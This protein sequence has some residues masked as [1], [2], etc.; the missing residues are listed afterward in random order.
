MK[1]VKTSSKSR[2]Q[3]PANSPNVLALA[4]QVTGM[5]KVWKTL[6]TFNQR[7]CTMFYLPKNIKAA[8]SKEHPIPA[9]SCSPQPS[10]CRTSDRSGWCHSG[11]VLRRPA[12]EEMTGR[13]EHDAKN[14]WPVESVWRPPIT[15]ANAPSLSSGTRLNMVQ[16]QYFS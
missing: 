13:G 6:G 10:H 3:T 7:N 12:D 16:L 11:G 14:V 1:S 2:W 5:K 9:T 4:S 15:L 8:N